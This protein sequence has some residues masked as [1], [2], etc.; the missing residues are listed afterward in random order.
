MGIIGVVVI[1]VIG[2]LLVFLLKKSGGSSP[3]PDH[4]TVESVGA[5]ELIAAFAKS[6]DFSKCELGD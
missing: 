4:P 5:N 3:D 2:I 6:P 1:A